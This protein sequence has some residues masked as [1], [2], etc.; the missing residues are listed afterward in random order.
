MRG[1]R[2]ARLE[3]RGQ[4]GEL[5][6]AAGPGAHDGQVILSTTARAHAGISCKGAP[7]IANFDGGGVGGEGERLLQA[8]G[9]PV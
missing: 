7:G 3:L 9:A 1:P 6:H 8:R 2:G 5:L 4:I